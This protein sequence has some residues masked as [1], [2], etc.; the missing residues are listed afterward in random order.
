M[1]RGFAKV[2]LLQQIFPN[3]LVIPAS[4]DSENST[5]LVFK[6]IGKSENRFIIFR[7]EIRVRFPIQNHRG[8]RKQTKTFLFP[9]SIR[10]QYK[11]V[12]DSSQIRKKVLSKYVYQ[13]KDR[14]K[15]IVRIR[16]RD[17][18][19]KKTTTGGGQLFPGNFCLSQKSSIY[20]MLCY[21]FYLP[22]NNYKKIKEKRGKKKWRGDLTET[23]GAYER[24]GLL[25]LRVRDVKH[26][27]KK[28][29]RKVED[30]K[31]YVLWIWMSLNFS[32]PRSLKFGSVYEH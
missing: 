10:V 8:R 16:H 17:H 26:R 9:F 30:G 31:I 28:R 22:H 18:R 6:H 20:V 23:I 12:A 15:Q 3:L 4:L 13:T 14:L 7:H 2:V 21:L 27:L 29:W 32:I 1:K 11:N 19:S 25:E 24:F 5:S